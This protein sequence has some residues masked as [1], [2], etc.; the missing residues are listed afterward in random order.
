MVNASMLIPA[1]ANMLA[2]FPSSPGTFFRKSD[3]SVLTIL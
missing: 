2:N 1:S 3:I